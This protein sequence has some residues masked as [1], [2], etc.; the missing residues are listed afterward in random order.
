MDYEFIQRVQIFSRESCIELLKAVCRRNA[1]M[2]LHYSR[3]FLYATRRQQEK[4]LRKQNWPKPRRDFIPFERIAPRWAKRIHLYGEEAFKK[5]H[6]SLEVYSLCIVGESHI[7]NG[8]NS[9]Y[10]DCQTCERFGMHFCNS[11]FPIRY[12]QPFTEHF[13]L[14]H[15]R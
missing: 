7:K 6:K 11:R 5:Y 8:G 4:R 3:E 13:N 9:D 1:I 15:L 14:V 10:D 12:I 2:S